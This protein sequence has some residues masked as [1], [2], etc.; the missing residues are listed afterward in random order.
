LECFKSRTIVSEFASFQFNPETYLF[1]ET[2]GEVGEGSEG[3]ELLNIVAGAPGLTFGDLERIAES[4]GVGRNGA[5][6]LRKD[7]L[8]RGLLRMETDSKS[9]AKRLFLVRP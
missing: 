6:E 4:R 3:Q 7:L 1:T 9:R 8:K 2:G 5:R